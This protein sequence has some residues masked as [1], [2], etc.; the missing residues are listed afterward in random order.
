LVERRP[1]RLTYVSCHPAA[2]ARDL[3]ALA[4]TYEIEDL[5]F[6]D[7]FP[8]TAHIEVVAQLRYRR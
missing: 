6:V 7:L 3:G 1:S 8:Q 2:L 4:R 5:T